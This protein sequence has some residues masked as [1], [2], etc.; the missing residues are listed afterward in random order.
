MK[1]KEQEGEVTY[2]ELTKMLKSLIK[3]THGKQVTVEPKIILEVAYEEIQASNDSSSGYSLRFPRVLKVRFD[4]KLS[5]I[6][7]IKDVVKIYEEQRSR[8]N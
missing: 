5:D 6:N 3:E 8:S 2:E 7:T 4:K 1:E